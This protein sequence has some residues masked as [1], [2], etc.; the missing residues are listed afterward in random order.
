MSGMDRVSECGHHDIGWFPFWRYQGDEQ[1]ITPGMPATWAIG[2][3]GHGKYS[4]ASEVRPA[5]P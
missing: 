3:G 1:L 2:E 4:K 5:Q